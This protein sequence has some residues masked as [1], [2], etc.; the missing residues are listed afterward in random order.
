MTD[1]NSTLK[2]IIN[3]A[4]AQTIVNRRFDAQLSSYGLGFNDFVI[5]YHL[6]QAPH[7][8]MRRVDLADKVGFTASG[9]T[10]MLAPME[11]IGLVSRE[12]NERD[13]RVSYV[14][15]APGGK[16]LLEESVKTAEHVA[17]DIFPKSKTKKIE[18]LPEILDGIGGL[19]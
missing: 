7:E 3:L 14:V 8:K 9:I 16:R 10:R 5:L 6:S 19:L 12:S 18:K 1:I 13:A 15:L 11:K 4:K 17:L 2:F